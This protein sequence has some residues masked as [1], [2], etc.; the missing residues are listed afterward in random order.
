MA[1]ATGIS[2]EEYLAT[3][4][5]PDCDC[6]DGVLED[7]DVGQ[8]DHSY[9]QAALC[10]CLFAMRKKL[11]CHVF[12]EQRS[13][14]TRT[15]FRIPDVCVVLGSYPEEQVF[16]RV[17]RKIQDYFAFGVKYVWVI[18]PQERR[19]WI[20]TGTESREVLDGVLRTEDPEITVFLNECPIP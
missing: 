2:I 4:Y 8:R 16:T 11:G 18:D 7:R 12:D 15:R 9:F 6:V 5:E 20:Y 19:G 17:E 14:V 1:T 13:R 3:D 10:A